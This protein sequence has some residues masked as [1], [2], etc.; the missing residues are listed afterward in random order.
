MSGA[1]ELHDG[2]G[3]NPGPTIPIDVMMLAFAHQPTRVM[4]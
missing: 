2:W 4:H 3:A 1:A